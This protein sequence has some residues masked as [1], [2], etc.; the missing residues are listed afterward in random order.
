MRKTEKG[1]KHLKKKNE[2]VSSTAE[3]KKPAV[4]KKKSETVSSAA[5]ERKPAASKKKKAKV[6]VGFVMLL[7]IIALLAFLVANHYL[8]KINRENL[9]DVIDA[10]N[11][12]FDGDGGEDGIDPNDIF[13]GDVPT[14]ND[15]NLVNILLV[16][17]DARP[18]QGR[19]RSDTMI[20]CSVNTKTKEISL[21]SF[22]RDLYVQLPGKYSDNR[23][24][25]P[26]AFGGF[27]LLKQT[28]QLNFGIPIDGCFEVNFDGFK[29]VIE[30]LGGVNIK[31]TS[32][33]ASLINRK[34]GGNLTEGPN[35]LNADQA[36]YYARIRKLDSDFGRT[37]R[38][39]KV[40][41]EV[42]NSLKG[43]S[44]KELNALANKILP[45][46]TTDMT[47]KQIMAL[48]AKCYG[49]L[50]NELQTYHV[51]ADDAYYNAMIKGMAVLV[52][53]LPL[54]REQLETYMPL[55][56]KK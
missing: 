38:Q 18:G 20:V 26:Y 11:E 9:D 1:G 13:W 21:I 53:D 37:D 25:A 35:E 31:L 5:E 7:L 34:V 14:F 19:Q 42:F 50:D 17:Q 41:T 15:K 12:T 51:P 30:I 40:L 43:S 28:I 6:A 8:D 46:M 56:N 3:E 4:S 24:N 44:L 48:I 16:G 22:L 36:L 49:A 29:D 47:N 32:A 45:C 52:P 33:E 27:D 39:R 2:T 10:E 23:L 55:T 54:I